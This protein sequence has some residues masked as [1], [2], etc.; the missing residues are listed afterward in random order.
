MRTGPVARR[1]PELRKW[2][3]TGA[4]VSWKSTGNAGSLT[5]RLSPL[6]L[7]DDLYICLDFVVDAMQIEAEN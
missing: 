7:A 3:T 4:Q 6:S 1:A 5:S 2:R